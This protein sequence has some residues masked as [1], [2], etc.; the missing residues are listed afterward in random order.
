MKTQLESVQR[1]NIKEDRVA[2]CPQYGCN[3]IKKVKPL[4]L[5]FLGF[6]KYPKCLTHKIPLVFVDE[7]VGNFIQAVNSCLY[8][9]SSLPPKD[10][11]TRIA[12]D[13]PNELLTFIND[14]MFCNPIGRG[15]R[16]VSRYF[17]GLSRAYINLLSRK[18]SKAIQSENNSK[19]RYSMLRRGLDKITKEFT[20]FLQELRENSLIF[21]DPDKITPFSEIVY[22]IIQNWLQNRLNLTL[23]SKKV[24]DE[25]GDSQNDYLFALKEKYDIILHAGT[26]SLLLG[27][28]KSVLI[29]KFSAFEIFSAYH[30]FLYSGLCVKVCRN[31]LEHLLEEIKEFI[32]IDLEPSVKIHNIGDMN[33]TRTKEIKF[34]PTYFH[35][36][37]KN[38]QII[39]N[40]LPFDSQ[41]KKKILC[42]ALD[43][44]STA[45]I[46]GMTPSDLKNKNSGV[47]SVIFVFFSL[48]STDCLRIKN[49]PLSYSSICKS[50]G[51]DLHLIGLSNNKSRGLGNVS[52]FLPKDISE[53]YSKF[54]S[55]K[56]YTGRLSFEE[57]IIA[58][59]N[60]G[61]KSSGI[62]GR[63]L[64]PN[65]DS[66]KNNFMELEP[67]EY[68]KLIKSKKGHEVRIP[69]WC[70]LSMHKPWKAILSNLLDG[71]WCRKCADEDKI[72]FSLDKLKHLAKIRG[73]EETG[74]EG[75]VL[76]SKN[77]NIE[78]MK[79]TYDKLTNNNKPSKTSFWWDCCIID[80]PSWKTT[81][82]HISY[83]KSWCPI[84][85]MG[86]YTHSE[87]LKLAKIRGVE[88]TG[89]EGKILDSKNSDKELTEKTYDEL[90]LDKKPSAVSFWWSCEKN[91]VPFRNN[92]A[93]IRRGQWCPICSSMEGKFEKII[94]Q[95]FEQIFRTPFPETYL[96]N[97]YLL[98]TKMAIS[99]N[100]LKNNKRIKLD[101][102]SIQS[103]SRVSKFY[104]G[105]MRFD[106]Y[107]EMIINNQKMKIAFEYNGI[108]HYEFPNYWF[109][110]SQEGYKEWLE[111]I[112][113]DQLKKEICKINNIILIEIPYF[114]DKS[115]EHSNKIQSYIISEFE[116]KTG[117]KLRV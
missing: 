80:H 51:D 89:I 84:C 52:K 11:L 82:S 105:K 62:E 102:Y 88:E 12:K 64:S 33:K 22:K 91:H 68:Y 75:K 34:D 78:L 30:E 111:Y 6:N 20:D 99:L 100:L 112:K 47:L 42:N 79:E 95:H 93:N 13:A 19:V 35:S 117:I 65:Y 74:I 66:D 40:H 76:D 86:L 41:F 109:E 106:G 53:K 63:A 54:Y 97:L 29:E 110:N 85:K 104:K 31:D 96:R 5:R 7:F 115:L 77:S 4:K 56:L 58:I 32:N 27:K 72:I 98:Y 73:R 61:L 1:K 60:L 15:G 16:I 18:Q 37:K 38:I 50:L 113:R 92:P 67:E 8:D 107:A 87:L 14:W 25:E 26:G 59:K 71:K 17:D 101:G 9:H 55:R 43:L 45:L 81:P 114:I 24:K 10:L 90:T 23:I 2:I 57:F 103:N 21:Y 108:Q 94:R 46:N 48:F 39:L 70:G 44:Y 69:V 28:T 83:D 3:I 36:L 116:N 49:K